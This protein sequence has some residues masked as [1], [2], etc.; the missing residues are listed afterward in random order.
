MLRWTQIFFHLSAQWKSPLTNHLWTQFLEKYQLDWCSLVSTSTTFILQ[1]YYSWG[2][3]PI[4]KST[5]GGLPFST[6]RLF[7]C[8]NQPQK[9]ASQFTVC[10]FAA[11]S[12]YWWGNEETKCNTRVAFAQE[13][14]SHSI[15]FQGQPCWSKQSRK[16]GR[17]THPRN[18]TNW[19]H[20]EGHG[21]GIVTGLIGLCRF[22]KCEP[23]QVWASGSSRHTM[24]GCIT[25]LAGLWPTR[26]TMIWSCWN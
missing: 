12:P 8:A 26:T 13:I 3:A 16:P 24:V 20:E 22:K 17:K 23:N 4:S 25:W 15:T 1:C 11:V 7:I 14:K 5:T 19:A 2:C 18:T 9:D 21:N 6:S 10:D